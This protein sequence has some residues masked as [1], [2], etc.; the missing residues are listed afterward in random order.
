MTLV[1]PGSV[2]LGLTSAG[3]VAADAAVGPYANP[4]AEV[5]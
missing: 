1:D 4:L 2:N 3:A 5:K